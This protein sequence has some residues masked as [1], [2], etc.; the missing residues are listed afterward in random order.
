LEFLLLY[1]TWDLTP[2]GRKSAGW[3]NGPKISSS[4]ISLSTVPEKV[5][6]EPASFGRIGSKSEMAP[7]FCRDSHKPDKKL[8]AAAART[9]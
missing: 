7:I 1:L 8:T 2:A 3:K 9:N 6:E 4:K 5:N